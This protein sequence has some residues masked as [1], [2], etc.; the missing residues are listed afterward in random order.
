M[1]VSIGLR[2]D[3]SAF[4]IV[5]RPQSYR[6]LNRSSRHR[7]PDGSPLSRRLLRHPREADPLPQRGADAITGDAAHRQTILNH[8]AALRQRTARVFARK[9][10]QALPEWALGVRGWGLGG[11]GPE[12]G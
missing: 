12:Q 11:K 3:A 8:L 9:A 2:A 7:D 6:S 4:R 10:Y 1:G 5:E